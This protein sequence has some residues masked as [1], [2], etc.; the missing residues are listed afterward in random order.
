VTIE[1][2][3]ICG[4]PTKVIYAADFRAFDA[5]DPLA[6]DAVDA[7]DVADVISEAEHDYASPA[8]NGGWTVMDIRGGLFDAGRIV[9]EGTHE[10][11]RIARGARPA[12]I[13][14]RASEGAGDVELGVNDVRAPLARVAEGP[15]TV[16]AARLVN[17]V[18]AGDVV[19]LRAVRG[20]Y[21]NFHVYLT[22]EAH[23]AVTR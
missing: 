18:S 6:D 16:L 11:F 1:G 8:P 19:T 21:R 7:I 22:R 12:T 23:A 13:F 14:V 20:E 5:V 2:N 15:W 4:G 9:P 10:R 17:G 3:V